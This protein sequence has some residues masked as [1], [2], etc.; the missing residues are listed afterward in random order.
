MGKNNSITLALQPSAP[1]VLSERNTYLKLYYDE[2]VKPAVEA[3]IGDR[4][5]SRQERFAITNKLLAEI[6]NK[7]PESLK[8]EIRKVIEKDR[9]AIDAERALSTSVITADEALGPKE[10]LKYVLCRLLQYLKLDAI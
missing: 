1:R 9:Q 7:E 10:Y 4:S 2:R 5:I 6:Y 3:E 8:E